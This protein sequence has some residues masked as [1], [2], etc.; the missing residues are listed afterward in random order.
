MNLKVVLLFLL[1]LVILAGVPESFARPEYLT[2]LKAVYGDGS[3]GTCHIKASGGGPRNSYGTLFE[4]Q[5]NFATDPS[6]AL[7]AIGQPLTAALTPAATLIP[8]AANLTNNITDVNETNENETN[9]TEIED[10]AGKAAVVPV[11]TAVEPAPPVET[12][13][14]PTIPVSTT[15]PS[16]GFGIV[17]AIVVVLSIIYLFGKRR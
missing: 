9:A 16:P 1:T 3:C 14:E 13:I 12:T 5:P 6:T 10:E 11:N 7:K 4:N 2:S 15:K 17:M 8:A